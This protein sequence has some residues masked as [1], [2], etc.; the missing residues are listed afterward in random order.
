[1]VLVLSTIA[2]CR[3]S[4]HA[5]SGD[6]QGSAKQLVEAVRDWKKA[7]LEID[8]LL[9]GPGLAPDAARDKN[10]EAVAPKLDVRPAAFGLVHDIADPDAGVRAV[11]FVAGVRELQA[12]LVSHIKAARS[13]DKIPERKGESQYAVVLD[14]K[15]VGAQLVEV[16]PTACNG[17][18][19]TC[20]PDDVPSGIAYR[21]APGAPMIMGKPAPVEVEYP[22][23]TVIP[24]LPTKI[25]ETM[26]VGCET[27]ATRLLYEAR[28]KDLRGRTH[29]LIE[30]GNR[31]ESMLAQLAAR[32]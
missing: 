27:G 17:K 3:G 4:D 11:E 29:E 32:P 2:V 21:T 6:S 10:L 30:T 25:L 28:L 1:V 19:N 7:A 5:A 22:T 31:L 26:L 12:R 16:G 24:L 14:D 8:H 15:E 23:K 9:E 18:I 13:D 20:K